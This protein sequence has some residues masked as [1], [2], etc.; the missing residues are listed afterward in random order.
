M[1]SS[2]STRER[3]LDTALALVKTRGVDITMA[4]FAAAA[5]ISRQALYLH[6]ADRAALLLDLA[7]YA[8]EKRGLAQEQQKIADAPDGIAALRELASLQARMNPGIWPIAQLVDAVRR[9]DADAERAW[10]DRLESRL[11]GCRKLVSRLQK[12][13][14]L[15]PD[16]DASA[17]ADI[18]WTMTSLRAWEDLVLSRGWTA[19][20]YEQRI[21][22]LLIR[23]LTEED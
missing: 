1:V 19:R 13:Q 18:L 9:T 16:L 23:A 21:T 11:K 7:R 3:I 4:E 22:A 6:Y 17:A 2:G 14:K 20:Q 8:D 15:R 5:G 12:E 10:Q